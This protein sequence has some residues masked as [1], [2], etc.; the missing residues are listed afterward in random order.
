M[1]SPQRNMV[2][3]DRD[4]KLGTGPREEG[5]TRKRGGDDDIDEDM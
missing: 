2:Q 3:V 1:K 5:S 4:A